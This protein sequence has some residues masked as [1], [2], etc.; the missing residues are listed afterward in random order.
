MESAAVKFMKK[1]QYF[2]PDE[3]YELPL[4]ANQWIP[5]GVRTSIDN[6]IKISARIDE[7]CTGG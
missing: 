3:K 2:F 6:K 7:A 4:Y 5:L 1:D